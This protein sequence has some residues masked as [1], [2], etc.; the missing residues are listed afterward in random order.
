MHSKDLPGE[1]ADVLNSAFTGHSGNRS[2]RFQDARGVLGISL[3]GYR[4]PPVL[5]WLFLAGDAISQAVKGEM[6]VLSS[7]PLNSM[8]SALCRPLRGHET[9]LGC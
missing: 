4:I 8:A 2:D 1:Q 3:Q 7:D 9:E 5:P 6:S